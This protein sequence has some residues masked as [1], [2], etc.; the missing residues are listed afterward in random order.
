MNVI[1][2]TGDKPFRNRTEAS[3]FLQKVIEKSQHYDIM[4]VKK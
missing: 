4:V 3:Q 1:K 2:I